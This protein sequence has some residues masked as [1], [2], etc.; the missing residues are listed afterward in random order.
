MVDREKRI[1]E[2]QTTPARKAKASFKET[3]LNW[4]LAPWLEF[5]V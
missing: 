5:E 3:P 2:L 1:K 4:L